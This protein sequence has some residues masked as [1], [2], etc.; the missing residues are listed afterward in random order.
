MPRKSS[1]LPYVFYREKG[2]NKTNLI[3]YIPHLFLYLV[4]LPEFLTCTA[5]GSPRT[6]TPSLT[7]CW[8]GLG[9][10]LSLPEPFSYSIPE[11]LYV[12]SRTTH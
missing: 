1:E 9:P 10:A 8:R 12:P 7:W 5:P 11:L 3:A 4:S 6:A 2:F